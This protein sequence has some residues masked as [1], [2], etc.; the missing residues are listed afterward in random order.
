[1]KTIQERFR[2]RVRELQLAKELS[3]EELALTAEKGMKVV[4]KE[5]STILR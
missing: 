3:Q 4:S 1:M 5:A 2:Q